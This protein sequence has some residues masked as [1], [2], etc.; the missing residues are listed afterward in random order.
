MPELRE[1]VEPAAPEPTILPTTI[2]GPTAGG[3][4]ASHA[5]AR[6]S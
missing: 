4:R 1:V 3:A 6:E 2:I 5:H